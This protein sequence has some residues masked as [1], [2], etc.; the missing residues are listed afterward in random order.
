MATGDVFEAAFLGPMGTLL[1][2]YPTT[3]LQVVEAA[4][5]I[6]I[7][8]MVIIYETNLPPQQW[9]HG[10]IIDIAPGSDGKVRFVDIKTTKG[11]IRRAVH[12]VA[13]L[14]ISD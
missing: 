5:H 14:P 2:S 8:Q 11:I 6:E 9:S 10:R 1:Y 7:G 13:P 4:D 12:K 3:T